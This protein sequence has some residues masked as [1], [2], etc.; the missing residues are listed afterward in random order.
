VVVASS[1]D[2]TPDQA[3]GLIRVLQP[4]ADYLTRLVARMATRGWPQDDL[5]YV[6]ALR[7]RDSLVLLLGSLNA[8]RDRSE[9]PAWMRARGV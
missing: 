9:K 1:D 4:Q 7:S 8:L 5:V 6:R 2:L 3:A